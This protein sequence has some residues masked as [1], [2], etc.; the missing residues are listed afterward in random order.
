[1]KI[2]NNVA[3]Q[4]SQVFS[5]AFLKTTHTVIGIL[6]NAYRDVCGPLVI[7]LAGDRFFSNQLK[8]KL[9]LEPQDSPIG[10]VVTFSYSVERS[11]RVTTA[12]FVYFWN[13]TDS[14]KY[15]NHCINPRERKE[16]LD[17]AYNLMFH[18]LIQL[19]TAK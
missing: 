2:I 13:D 6:T 5:D 11:S 19:K 15:V 17:L 3:V 18:P 16:L 12:L 8:T 4:M 7:V 10:E 1:M 9:A 14:F